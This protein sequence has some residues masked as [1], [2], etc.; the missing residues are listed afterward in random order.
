LNKTSGQALQAKTQKS[1]I[2]WDGGSNK[3]NTLIIK[4]FQIRMTVKSLNINSIIILLLGHLTSFNYSSFL[5]FL[6]AA[7]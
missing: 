3:Q 6:A 1:L 5:L 4:V 7:A 2:L